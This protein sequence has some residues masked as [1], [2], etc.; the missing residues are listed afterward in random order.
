MARGRPDVNSVSHKGADF[1]A[2]FDAK[3]S[4]R[5]ED[6]ADERWEQAGL[7]H[8]MT[9]SRVTKEKVGYWTR[10]RVFV[11]VRWGSNIHLLPYPLVSHL[12][13]YIEAEIS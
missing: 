12:M 5:L 9:P 7:A 3:P 4:P 2:V 8:G 13:M 11:Q 6:M 10:R 1:R